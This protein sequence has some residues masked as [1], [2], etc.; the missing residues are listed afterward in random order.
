ML[1]TTERRLAYFFCTRRRRRQEVQDTLV[2]L[3]EFGPVVVIGGM[4]RDLALAGNQH[5]GS[6]VDFVVKPLDMEQFEV[7]MARQSAT[8]NKFGGYIWHSSHW[9][10]DVW[11]LQKTW[12]FEAGHVE[13][14]SFS[15]LL[16]C[17]FFDADAIIYDLRLKKLV[18]D[19]GYF[20]RLK[21]RE[22]EINLLAN[23]NP[24]G[25]A[26]RALRYAAIKKFGWGPQLCKF[27]AKQIDEN[28]WEEL[29]RKEVQSFRTWYIEEMDQTRVQT[30]LWRHLRNG[31]ESIFRSG[32]WCRKTQEEFGFGE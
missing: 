6:D 8:R 29:K 25:N 24:V 3:Q 9:R 2:K 26:V 17:T 32:E 15:D 21:R 13:V 18:C 31:Q 20:E 16:K 27:V 22:L 5:F 11:P 4:I 28:G 12:A 10:I 14:D 23:P 1:R 7:F 30:E 19:A